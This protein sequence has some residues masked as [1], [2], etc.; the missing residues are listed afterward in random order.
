MDN[1]LL[2]NYLIENEITIRLLGDRTLTVSG[3]GRAAT[4]AE[5]EWRDLIAGLKLRGYP[6]RAEDGKPDVQTAMRWLWVA[7]DSLGGSRGLERALRVV[8]ETLWGAKLEQAHIEGFT[9]S[10]D[11]G[12]PLC[13]T[14]TSLVSQVICLVSDALRN[15]IGPHAEEAFFEGGAQK[16][17]EIEALRNEARRR[18]DPVEDYGDLMDYS[19]GESI[20]PATRDELRASLAAAE[21]DEG[22]GVIEVGERSCYVEG[23]S[24]D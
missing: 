10:A 6:R 15:Q 11:G 13:G 12:P 1:A 20:R 24:P 4:L 22:P 21:H 3:G 2:W 18:A 5:R 7:I 17:Q 14:K 19:T 16:A 9:P 8:G 23:G